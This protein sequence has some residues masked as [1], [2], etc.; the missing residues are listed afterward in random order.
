MVTWKS[1]LSYLLFF[2]VNV[3][4]FFKLTFLLVLLIVQIVILLLEHL[5]L[6]NFH[7]LIQI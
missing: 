2:L 1:Q 3:F 5:L 7:K 4:A 6:V